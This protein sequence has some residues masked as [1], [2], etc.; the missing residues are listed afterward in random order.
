MA[1]AFVLSD[2]SIR[3]S[4]GFYLDNKGGNMERFRE[5]PVMLLGHDSTKVIGAWKDVRVE[6]SRIIA[7]PEFDEGDTL[8]VETRGKVERGYLKGASLGILVY[9][10][11]NVPNQ[12]TGV[13]ELHV[14]DWELLEA[15]I[16]AI[17][18]N[19]SALRV[20]DAEGNE[21]HGKELSAHLISLSVEGKGKITETH[22]NMNE[23]ELTA[24]ALTA[25]GL[26]T[27][28]SDMEAL[29][30]AIVALSARATGAEARVKELEADAEKQKKDQAKTLINDAVKAGKLSAD[31]KDK[32][33]ALA[34]KD[35]DTVSATLSGMSGRK[36]IADQI[37]MS[38]SGAS[39]SRDGWDYMRWLKEDP[40][41]L[42][43]MKAENFEAW[44]TLHDNYGR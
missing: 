1:K 24:E 40:Q 4:H 27:T 39:K 10:A 23:I 17:P 30:A 15:S 37:N 43:Q 12:D 33:L 28:P 5:N 13:E 42:A 9:G 44:Q 19:A 11:K 22:K 34:E 36:S 35:Y 16:V 18:S 2:E 25:L 32:W 31:Q 26:K 7:E 38:S 29:S 21:L 14:T 20:L 6:G 3:N 41:G 8:A